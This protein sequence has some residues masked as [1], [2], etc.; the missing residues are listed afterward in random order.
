MEYDPPLDPGIAEYVVSLN[1]E[2]VDTYES[3]E[4]GPGHSYAEPTIR[5][6][7][8]QAE[9]FRVMAIAQRK[10]LPIKAVRRIWTVEDGEPHGPFWELVLWETTC[11]Q[12]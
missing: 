12:R 7:G 2:G 1:E 11:A 4:G 8:D 9:G 3:C 6:H 5:F 10:R